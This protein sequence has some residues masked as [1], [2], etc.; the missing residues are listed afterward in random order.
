MGSGPE[1]ASTRSDGVEAA[2]WGIG[3]EG[4]NK[5]GIRIRLSGEAD[6]LAQFVFGD[7]CNRRVLGVQHLDGLNNGLYVVFSNRVY[8]G[9]TTSLFRRKDVVRCCTGRE[10]ADGFDG[11]RELGAVGLEGFGGWVGGA[12][13]IG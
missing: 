1:G 4:G 13:G 10:G 11:L 3:E 2:I 7:G 8:E 5:G 12:E 6:G 9:K